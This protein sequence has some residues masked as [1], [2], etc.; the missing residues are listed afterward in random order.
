MR[1]TGWSIKEVIFITLE[2]NSPN[3]YTIDIWDCFKNVFRGY[4]LGI[5]HQLV[6]FIEEVS[7]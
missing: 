6:C 4:L 2:I 7:P 5:V 3:I 1:E